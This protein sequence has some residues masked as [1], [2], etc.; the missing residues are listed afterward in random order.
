ME[1]LRSS[2]NKKVLGKF[3]DECNSLLITEF[4]ALNPKVY[5][6]KYQAVN[7]EYKDERKEDIFKINH[8]E[9]LENTNV[10]NKRTCKGVDKIT[11]KKDI[12]HQD[13]IDVITTDKVVK[14]D[15]YSIRSFNHQLFT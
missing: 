14:K 6:F 15:V 9:I 13:Y 7:K 1:D 10:D 12:T 5:S 4:L 11:V 2:E 3:K 8:K